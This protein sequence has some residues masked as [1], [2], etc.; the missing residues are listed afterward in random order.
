MQI[1]LTPAQLNRLIEV[2]EKSQNEMTDIN[3]INYLKGYQ[4]VELDEIPF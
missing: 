1:R 4:P 2:L 3:L